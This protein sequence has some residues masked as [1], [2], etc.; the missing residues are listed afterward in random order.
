MKNLRYSGF[1]F[2]SLF[3]S[4]LPNH[5]QRLHFDNKPQCLI[6]ESQLKNPYN[7]GW[8]VKKPLVL[9]IIQV[10]ATHQQGVGSVNATL[11]G[12]FWLWLNC[13]VISLRTEI[14][15]QW[16]LIKSSHY[17]HFFSESSGLQGIFLKTNVLLRECIS[18][19]SHHC[20]ISQLSECMFLIST[21]AI[22]SLYILLF[23]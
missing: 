13:A 4:A 20:H 17:K 16:I 18:F 5:Q 8:D 15:Q 6:S 2:L 12:S 9:W 19:L 10:Q 21:S 11:F 22:D 14:S 1:L 23:L 7:Q 3:E